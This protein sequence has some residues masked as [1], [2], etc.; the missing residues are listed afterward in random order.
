MAVAQ[1][2]RAAQTV[3]ITGNEAVAYAM[4]QVNPNVVAAYPITPSTPVVETFSQYV[5]DGEVTSE[6]V[7]VESEHSAMAACVGAAAAGGRVMTAT[8]SMGLAYMN[9]VVWVAAGMRLPIVMAIAARAMSAPLNIHGDHSDMYGVR[10]AGWIQFYS[11]NTQEAYDNMILAVRISEHMDVRL[12]VMVGFDGFVTSHAIE[13]ITVEADE[14]VREFIGEYV[15]FHPLLDVDHPVTY[16]AWDRPAYYFEHRR[17]LDEAVSDALR[18]VP[19]IGAEWGRLTGRPGHLIETYRSEDAEWVVVG[20]ASVMETAEVVVDD[21]RDR[22]EKVGLVRL[23]V[24]RPFP[25]GALR[26][27]LE[28]KQAVAVLDRAGPGGGEFGILAEEVRS[29][30]YSFPSRPGIT[31]YVYGLGGRDVQPE[32]LEAVFAD[33]RADLAAGLADHPLRYINLRE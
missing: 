12:P 3:W 17:Q 20:M 30:L 28:G 1:E 9:E 5:A 13:T 24:F 31:S 21:L 33:L 23:R 16:G 7:A 6:F 22:G 4:R 19:E 15:P 2:V 32:H 27:A 18:V 14:T 10:D 29:A 8:G 11:K 26:Q 25:A